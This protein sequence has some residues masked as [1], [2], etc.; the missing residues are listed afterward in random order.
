MIGGSDDVVIRR[1]S[2]GIDGNFYGIVKVFGQENGSSYESTRN[3]NASIGGRNGIPGKNDFGVVDAGADHEAE[4]NREHF[5]TIAKVPFDGS[6]TVVEARGKVVV[7]GDDGVVAGR[8]KENNVGTGFN[9]IGI[10]VEL[11]YGRGKSFGEVHTAAFSNAF[12]LIN[13][14]RI[15]FLGGFNKLNCFF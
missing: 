11:F 8:G 14:F 13:N 12:D 4:T 2:F 10:G 15:I 6:E 1:S 7:V 3:A 9:R 5:A